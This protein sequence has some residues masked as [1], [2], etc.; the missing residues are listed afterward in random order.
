MNT[1]YLGGNPSLVE[2]TGFGTG[3]SAYAKLQCAVSDFEGD[4][5]VGQYAAAAMQ[6][7]WVAAGISP[8]AAAQA[9][10]A[11]AK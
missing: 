8:E 4:P 10:E 3:P 5:L 7:I 11:N 6:K 2:L 9:A 1:V